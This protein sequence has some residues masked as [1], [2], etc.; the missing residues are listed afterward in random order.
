MGL[1]N[2]DK[3]QDL[4]NEA[5]DMTLNHEHTIQPPQNWP[6][7]GKISINN[8]NMRYHPTLPPVLTGIIIFFKKRKKIQNFFFFLISF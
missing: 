6:S 8:L 2:V 3:V 7:K 1:S 4:Q 5:S